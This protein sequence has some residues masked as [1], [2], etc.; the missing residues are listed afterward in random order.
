VTR[1]DL[2]LLE[3]AVDAHTAPALFPRPISDTTAGRSKPQ[4]P[5]PGV[6]V[7]DADGKLKPEVVT[8]LELV[9]E[10]GACLCTGHLDLDEVRLLQ[11]AAIDAGVQRFLVTHVNWVPALRLNSMPVLSMLVAGA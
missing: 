4:L 6:T 5:G 9:A 7:L 11:D 2:E 10:A 1:P 8:M 3:G